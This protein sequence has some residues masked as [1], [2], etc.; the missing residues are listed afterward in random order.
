MDSDK[1]RD[2]IITFLFLFVVMALTVVVSFLGHRDVD[3]GYAENILLKRIPIM[4]IVLSDVDLATVK[5]DKTIRFSGNEMIFFS[6]GIIKKYSDLELKGHGNST[7]QG[8]KR[9]FQIKFA[10]KTELFGGVSARKWILVANDF[11]ASQLRNSVAFYLGRMINVQYMKGGGFAELIINDEYQGLYYAAPKVEIGKDSVDIRSDYGILM[12]LDNLYGYENNCY[13]SGEKM[14][15]IVSDAV[16]SDNETIA[17]KDFVESFDELER[18]TKLGDYE[19]VREIIDIDSFVRYYILNEFVVNPDAYVSSW[20]MYRD[21][22]DDKIHVGPGWDYD[23]AFGN[24]NWIWNTADNF[25]SPELDMV[26]EFDAMGGSFYL[27]GEL[28]EKKPDYSISRVVIRLMKMPEF[29]EE[30]RRIYNETLRG[31]KAELVD[32]IHRQAKAI[33]SAVLRNNKKWGE[34]DFEAEVNYL[35]D[36]VERRYDHFESVYGDDKN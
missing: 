23:F 25:Y 15:F 16:N 20:Y 32:F 8:D 9:P 33:K 18:A 35:L 26:R 27:D 30:V 10:K 13:Y 6:D 14:C 36:W 11:D 31:H 12:E 19:S 1:I 4:E 34:E 2:A 17:A 5:K 3:V 22:P 28:I 7:W 21:G 24:R 29:K